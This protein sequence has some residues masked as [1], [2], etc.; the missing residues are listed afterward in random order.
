[1]S[2]LAGH[3]MD[4]WQIDSREKGNIRRDIGVIVATVDLEAVYAVLMGALQTS[5]GKCRNEGMM[6]T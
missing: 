1:M 2:Y 5:V 4:A 3:R 6:R